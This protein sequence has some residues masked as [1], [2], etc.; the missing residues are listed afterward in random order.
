MSRTSLNITLTAPLIRANVRQRL[1]TL[2]QRTDLP[3]TSIA[4]RALLFGLAHLEGNLTLLFPAAA[5]PVVTQ[6]NTPAPM[7]NAPEHT[8]AQLRA[9]QPPLPIATASSREDTPA[10]PSSVEQST[11]TAGYAELAAVPGRTREPE[12]AP[13]AEQPAW[14]TTKAAARALE[15]TKA[16]FAMHLRRHP[17]LRQHSQMEG[18]TVLWDLDSLR[19]GWTK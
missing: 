17:E 3:P 10:L 6:P 14:V 11:A 12:P 16:A 7:G 19:A 5:A 2:A 4:A 13:R 8:E 18:R 1:D 15:K 9:A